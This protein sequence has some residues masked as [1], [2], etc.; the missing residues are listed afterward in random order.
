MSF[1]SPALLALLIAAAIV[2]AL[3]LWLLRWRDRQAARFG[4]AGGGTLFTG[5]SVGRP[6]LKALLVVVAIAL[7]AVSAARPQFGST[8][9][10]IRQ[11]GIAIA[12][13]ID[14]S[15]SMAATDRPPDRLSVVRE[16]VAG[17]LDRLQ[18][19][20]VGL[21]LF[22]GTA[23]PRF[24]LTRDL[25]AVRDVVGALEPGVRLVGPGSD[26]A[27]AIDA[28]RALVERSQADT[29][30]ILLLTDGDALAGDPF[31][32][33]S[34]AAAAGVRL[35]TAGV[36]SEEGAMIPVQDP[37]L[38]VTAK[39]DA[40]TGLPVISRLDPTFLEDL[41]RA[42]GGRF[43]RL[44]SPGALGALAADLAA[45]EASTF[46]ERSKALPIERY[47]IVAAIALALVLLEPLIAAAR[48]AVNRGRPLRRPAALGAGLILVALVAAACDSDAFRHNEAGTRHYDASR[49][50][51]AL[52]D[53]RA[54][55][56]A[57]PGDARLALN[58]GRTLHAL[59]EYERAVTA[60]AAAIG[61]NQVLSARAFY[62]LGNHR[63][64]LGDLVAARNAYIEALLLN[65]EDADAKFNLELVTLLLSG[66]TPPSPPAIGPS[67]ADVP[68]DGGAPA[69]SDATAGAGPPTDGIQPGGAPTEEPAPAQPPQQGQGERAAADAVLDDALA[70]LDRDAPTLEQALAVLDA[71][72]ERPGVDRLTVGADRTP[73][74]GDRDW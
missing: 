53:Y 23:F 24:P 36:G 68:A 5:R 20:R 58:V 51:E 10:V 6:A 73:V 65:P 72:R 2:V 9:T 48:R 59:G 66:P 38:G 52:R 32:A 46:T 12:L 25:N 17:L 11:E 3:T 54:A 18:G 50:D 30:A 67:G 29:R 15:A 61:D 26:L 28:A 62:N 43:V 74:A 27:A 63:L 45:L 47:Q 40:A 16:E 57:A 14:V 34:A 13:A 71:L 21:V 60:T 1:G 4:A 39:I 22:A 33:A 56:A 8:E 19:D 35:F 69:G 44:D 64:A 37:G 7:L 41:V 70:L 31:P 49:Y 42:G 55:Q